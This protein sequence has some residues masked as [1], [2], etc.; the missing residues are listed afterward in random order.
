[1][2]N[3][4][5]FFVF[6]FVALFFFGLLISVKVKVRN[7]FRIPCDTREAEHIWLWVPLEEEVLMKAATPLVSLLRAV[8]RATASKHNGYEV[9]TPVHTTDVGTRYYELQAS[10]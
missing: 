5:V 2:Y 3:G 7:F 8:K 4:K 6:W 9:T 1:M 10:R